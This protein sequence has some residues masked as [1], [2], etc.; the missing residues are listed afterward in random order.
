[1]QEDSLNNNADGQMTMRSWF[2]IAVS[3]FLISSV[4]GLLMRMAPVI[5]GVNIDFR[6]TLHAHSH[7]AL[8][9]WG[10]LLIAGA[11]R[12]LNPKMFSAPTAK[13]FLIISVLTNGVIAIAFFVQGYAAVS[14][15]ASTMHLITAYWF[16][17]KILQTVKE[18]WWRAAGWFMLISSL[19]LWG[20]APVMVLLEKSHPLYYLSVEFFLHFQLN[21]WFVAA[22]FA[23]VK[24]Q[25][26]VVISPLNTWLFVVSVFFTYALYPA[27]EF[28]SYVLYVFNALGIML[29]IPAIWQLVRAV[30]KEFNWRSVTG[31]LLF[32]GVF[33]LAVK[34]LFQM[35]LIFPELASQ[36]MANRSAV[37][38]FIHVLLLGG[39]TFTV[40]SV[41]IK[42][43]A[44]MNSAGWYAV[45][46][47][48]VLTEMLLLISA[49]FMF[50]KMKLAF[51][52]NGWLLYASV[53][54]PA[55]IIW[56][57]K[58][59]TALFRGKNPLAE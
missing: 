35:V 3:F 24:S 40:V 55:G 13:K 53:F 10:F 41:L 18:F 21:G 29:Q 37:V 57:L 2:V 39:V 23:V 30:V 1:M 31:V 43:D 49:A 17:F 42:K 14:I 52:I 9:A 32:M 48:F 26:K 50:F 28:G 11:C 8:M 58:N 19:G 7:T 6:N 4:F 22:T 5:E 16:V 12:F 44:M 54:I 25:Y 56:V 59:S 47:G 15:A 36:L 33:S 27:F 38:A 34:A 20:I 45:I 46:L 51:D